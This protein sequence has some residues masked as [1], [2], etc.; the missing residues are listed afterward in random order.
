MKKQAHPAPQSLWRVQLPLQAARFAL[1][2]RSCCAETVPAERTVKTSAMKATA[3]IF[4]CMIDRFPSL[5][6]KQ[7][8]WPAILPGYVQI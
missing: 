7:Q 3:L 4:F 1:L 2:F 6:S 8:G 5:V